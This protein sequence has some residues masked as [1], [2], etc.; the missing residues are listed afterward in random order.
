MRLYSIHIQN[1]KSLQDVSLTD[2]QAV[3]LL[4][5]PNNSGKSNMLSLIQEISCSLSNRNPLFGWDKNLIFNKD[6]NNPLK[7][8]LVIENEHQYFHLKFYTVKIKNVN[9]IIDGYLTRVVNTTLEDRHNNVILRK[10]DSPILSI[11]KLTIPLDQTAFNENNIASFFQNTCIYNI[12]PSTFSQPT[13]YE[14]SNRVNA[15]AS[16]LVSFL[17]V[18]RNDYPLIFNTIVTDLKTCIPTFE[19]VTITKTSEDGTFQS[20]RFFD[21]NNN[22]Y[23]ANEVSEGVLYFLAL[24]SIVHQP[25]PPQLLLLEEPEKGVH[26]RRIKEVMDYIFNLAETKAIQIIMTTHSP[27]VVDEFKDL[28]EAIYVFDRDT[29]ATTVKNL[30]R[31]VIE[32]FNELAKANH[33]KSFNISRSLGDHWTTGLL[34]GVPKT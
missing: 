6:E 2:L 17:D 31:D 22:S 25:E 29:D 9:S 28:E 16:N 34:G 1:Y 14:R 24:L 15:D 33:T 8:Y 5:G 10:T 32:P 18:M 21:K 12:N 30:Q 26:P 23:L 19:N 7:L 4:I 27:Y 20:I 11:H 3:N 13:K